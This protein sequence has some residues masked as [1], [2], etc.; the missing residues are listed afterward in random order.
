MSIYLFNYCVSL[1]RNTKKDHYANL[2]EM[3]V[4]DNRQ[5]LRTIKPLLSHKVRSPEKITLVEREEIINDDAENAEYS[6]ISGNR[7]PG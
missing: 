2:N 4:A 7:L 6:R 1:L 3:D 5:F